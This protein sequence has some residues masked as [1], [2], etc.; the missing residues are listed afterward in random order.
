MKGDK[1]G[2]KTRP[3]ANVL[4]QKLSDMPLRMISFQQSP[5]TSNSI[6]VFNKG[7]VCEFNCPEHPELSHKS[8][9]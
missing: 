1:S 6:S 9:H 2:Q 8:C 5:F 4:Q 7:P 3:V